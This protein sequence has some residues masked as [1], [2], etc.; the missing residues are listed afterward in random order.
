MG[1]QREVA[2]L[3]GWFARAAGGQ[4]QL[5]FVSGEA[6]VGKTTVVELGLG[7]LAARG[8]VRVGRGQCVEPY[9][10]GEPYLPWLEVLGRLA[11]G[12]GGAEVVAALRRYA[13]MWLVQLPGW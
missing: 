4:R 11:R 12:P 3:E 7:R 5:G 9:G 2:R 10:E 6:G 13:P 1:R 8:G